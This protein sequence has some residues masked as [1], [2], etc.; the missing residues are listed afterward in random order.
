MWDILDKLPELSLL[1]ELLSFLQKL[2]EEAEVN[3]SMGL[4]TGDDTI[5]PELELQGDTL[6]DFKC[7]VS[8]LQDEPVV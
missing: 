7:R 8:V 2:S 6:L 1:E 5:C 4:L 3:I